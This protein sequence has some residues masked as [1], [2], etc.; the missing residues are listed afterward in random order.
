MSRLWVCFVIYLAALAVPA[1]AEVVLVVGTIHGPKSPR[2]SVQSTPLVLRLSD[3]GV[4][5][6]AQIPTKATGILTGVTFASSTV[7]WA[8]G[9]GSDWRPLLLR[10]TGAGLTWTDLSNMLP[11]EPL[12]DLIPSSLAAVDKQVWLVSRSFRGMGPYIA[13]SRDDGATWRSL[14]SPEV[15]RATFTD[16]SVAGGDYVLT[17]TTASGTAIANVADF[18]GVANV[19]PSSNMATMQ[20]NAQKIDGAVSWLAGFISTGESV[21]PAIWSSDRGIARERQLATISDSIL[22]AVD[23]RDGLVVAGGMRVGHTSGAVLISASDGGETWY[24]GFVPDA[25]D[26]MVV[27]G[28]A[29]TESGDVWAVGHGHGTR[30]SGVFLSVDRGATWQRGAAPYGA[31][32]ALFAAS[33]APR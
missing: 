12:V 24:E 33:A 17:Q 10:S 20:A 19:A 2:E 18:G 25:L 14:V 32:S 26:R 21:R 9:L 13:T 28:V 15:V 31:S 5:T 1:R 3:G 16:I 23:A 6:E 29:I 11:V 30:E 22:Q 4:W 8:Y 27:R 7:V